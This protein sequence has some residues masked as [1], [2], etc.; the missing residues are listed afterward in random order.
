MAQLFLFKYD[1]IA[2]LPKNQITKLISNN[3]T[4]SLKTKKLRNPQKEIG[5]RKSDFTLSTEKTPIKY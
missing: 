2:F 3:Q 4:V 5:D 1:L